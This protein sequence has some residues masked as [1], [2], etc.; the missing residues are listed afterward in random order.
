MSGKCFLA[1]K[2]SNLDK[3]KKSNQKQLEAMN[4]QIK[5]QQFILQALSQ[6]Y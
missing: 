5:E 6:D 4:K 2:P 1:I 3:Q